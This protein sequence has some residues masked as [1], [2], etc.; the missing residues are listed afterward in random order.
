MLSV[1]VQRLVR[2]F[3]GALRR[4]GEEKCPD[5]EILR[6]CLHNALYGLV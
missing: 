6:F 3:K 4:P 2:V 5:P 1:F